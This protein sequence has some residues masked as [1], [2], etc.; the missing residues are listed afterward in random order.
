MPED[1]TSSPQPPVKVTI[2]KLD[3]VKKMDDDQYGKEKNWTFSAT[4]TS[5][6][7]EQS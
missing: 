4:I 2:L 3:P 1:D 5:R 7:A 6:Q